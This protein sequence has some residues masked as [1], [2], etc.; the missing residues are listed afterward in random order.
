[1]NRLFIMLISII[2]LSGLNLKAQSNE[3]FLS[4]S[5]EYVLKQVKSPGSTVF[6]SYINPSKV[7]TM[8]SEFGVHLDNSFNTVFLS[9][10]SQNM[11]GALIRF[12]YYIFFKNNRPC[13]MIKADEIVSLIDNR[14]QAALCSFLTIKGCDCLK[15]D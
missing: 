9:F 13:T 5:K 10:D 6:I 2:F 8:F 15:L 1:M 7:K 12:E 14:Q 11:Y 4:M 3:Q